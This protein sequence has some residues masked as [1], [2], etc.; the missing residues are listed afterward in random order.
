[1]SFISDVGSFIGSG[2]AENVFN[3]LGD[4][5]SSVKNALSSVGIIKTG[6][7]S[8]SAAGASTT[9]TNNAINKALSDFEGGYL[10]GRFG[11]VVP[12]AIFVGA[13]ILAIYLLKGK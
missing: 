1:M 11:K 4:A 3:S 5:T 2:K 9:K 6:D 10:Q 7:N 12:V 13:A 8:T